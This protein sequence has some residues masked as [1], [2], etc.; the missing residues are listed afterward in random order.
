MSGK[1]NMRRRLQSQSNLKTEELTGN[2]VT[3]GFNLEPEFELRLRVRGPAI[4]RQTRLSSTLNLKVSQDH[5]PVRTASCSLQLPSLTLE[6]HGYISS[7]AE[8]RYV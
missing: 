4:V 7:K 1:K 5:S 8:G 6:T 3:F 2:R